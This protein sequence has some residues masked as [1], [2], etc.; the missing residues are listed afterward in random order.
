MGGVVQVSC[1]PKKELKKD[2]LYANKKKE[3]MAYVQPEEIR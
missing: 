1:G 2:Q 3:G